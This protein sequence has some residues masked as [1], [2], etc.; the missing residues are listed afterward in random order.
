MK[1][2]V[3]LMAALLGFAVSA[4]TTTTAPTFAEESSDDTTVEESN[5][6]DDT[7]TADDAGEGD[8]TAEDDGA[9]SEEGAMQDDGDVVYVPARFL[10]G[11]AETVIERSEDEVTLRISGVASRNNKVDVNSGIMTKVILSPEGDNGDRYKRATVTVRN[12]SNPGHLLTVVWPDGRSR[13]LKRGQAI[14]NTIRRRD[15]Q[16][17][18][19]LQNSHSENPAE[20]AVS[21]RFY[22]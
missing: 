20:A 12:T 10:D 17:T 16:L 7:A 18:I 1:L 4:F 19:Y 21:V 15:G 14:S 8:E 13:L 3:W 22:R 2:R 6:T 9:S 5:D 11:P